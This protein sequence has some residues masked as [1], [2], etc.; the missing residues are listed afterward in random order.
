PTTTADITG[1]A[2]TVSGITASN[3]LYDGNTTATLNTTSAAL[4]GIVSGDTVT[5]GTGSAAG[6]FVTAAVGTGKTVTVS[7][8]TIGGA[9]T[10]NY[11]LTPPTTTADITGKTLAVSGIT[12]A[13]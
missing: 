5:L 6:A 11:T 4:V 10:G 2:L 9:S 12:A 8:L 1:K 7:G 13:N 3:K